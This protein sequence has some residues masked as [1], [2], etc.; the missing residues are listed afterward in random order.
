MIS[1]SQEGEYMNNKIDHSSD[2][3]LCKDEFLSDKE[4]K[5]IALDKSCQIFG[6]YLQKN[7]DV[8]NNRSFDALNTIYANIYKLYKREFNNLLP[9]VPIDQSVEEDR[10][11]CLIDGVRV[12]MLKKYLQS[13][14]GMSEEAYRRMWNLPDDYPMVAPKYSAQRR[15]LAKLSGLGCL[16]K[17]KSLRKTRQLQAASA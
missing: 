14:H 16:P 11:V 6:V 13:T 15:A 7:I 17:G 10:I 4:I 3:V 2:A 1:S 9:A 5:T 8:L 12:K